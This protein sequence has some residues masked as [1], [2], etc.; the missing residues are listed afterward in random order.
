VAN[1][2]K[3]NDK[4]GQLVQ[5]GLTQLEAKVYVSL[6]QIG[7]TS[8]YRVAKNARIHRTEAYRALRRLKKLG[9]VEEYI[10]R[11]A[12]FKPIPP[13]KGIQLL[14]EDLEAK[15]EELNEAKR[16]AVS[17]LLSVSTVRPEVEGRVKFRFIEGA[18]NIRETIL[19]MWRNA[20]EEV[21]FARDYVQIRATAME[22]LALAH[23]LVNNGIR[24]RGITDIR[25]ENLQDI[26]S[27]AQSFELRHLSSISVNLDVIDDSEALSW[28]SSQDGEEPLGIWVDNP[29]RVLVQREFFEYLWRSAVPWELRRDEIIEEK[30]AGYC[31]IL[32]GGEELE[33]ALKGICEGAETEIM[34]VAGPQDWSFAVDTLNLLSRNGETCRMRCLAPIMRTNLRQAETLAKTCELQHLETP[35]LRMVLS[36][37]A[38]LIIKRLGDGPEIGLWTNIHDL[39]EGFW[40]MTEH[41]WKESLPVGRRIME[42]RSEES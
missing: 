3:P 19:N 8:A 13:A 4:I 7:T 36:D 32:W 14:I 28:F 16:E 21:F 6:L 31:R 20:K 11:P 12:L 5:F 33:H 15:L 30:P 26:S 18:R 1:Y 17:W 41:L 34:I 24:L 37:R 9:L 27:I 38:F 2:Q 35:P 39:V 23:T 29:R 42:L 40:M 10:G 22:E 25:E